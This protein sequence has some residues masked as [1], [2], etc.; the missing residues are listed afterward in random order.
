L[1][2]GKHDVGLVEI[3]GF[4]DSW[5]FGQFFPGDAFRRYARHFGDW[6]RLLH[7]PHPD[8][9][10]SQADRD[11]LRKVEYEIDR[12]RATLFLVETNEWRPVAELNIDGALVE[13]REKFGAEGLPSVA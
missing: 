3:K 8:D 1:F 12:L 6:A 9:R 4:D 13:W 7:A 10:L 5:G 2:L 11:A